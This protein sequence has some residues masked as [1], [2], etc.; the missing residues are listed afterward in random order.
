MSFQQAVNSLLG[1][2]G[3][4]DQLKYSFFF[5]FVLLF[6]FL[7]L[8]PTS[9]S[10]HT[11][12]IC[13]E[14]RSYTSTP[15]TSDCARDILAACWLLKC[16]VT[17]MN[18]SQVEFEKSTFYLDSIAFWEECKLRYLPNQI[19]RAN[20]LKEILPEKNDPFKNNFLFL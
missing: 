7:S 19:T 6:I 16:L 8:F 18:S 12:F 10:S 3:P 9:S 13:K 4:P 17:D 11:L 20:N 1:Y 5:A 15:S 14:M 2:P